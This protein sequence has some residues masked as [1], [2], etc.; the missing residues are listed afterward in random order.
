MSFERIQAEE[1]KLQIFQKSSG[2]SYDLSFGSIQS[3]IILAVVSSSTEK[4][5]IEI[6]SNVSSFIPLEM[7]HQFHLKI[8]DKK[9]YISDAFINSP[10]LGN[11]VYRLDDE[12]LQGYDGVQMA[13]F[14][15]FKPNGKI[16]KIGNA[17]VSTDL[18]TF[19]TSQYQIN[20]NSQT[21][22]F[23]I[24]EEI[25]PF[26]IAAIRSSGRKKDHNYMLSYKEPIK[27]YRSKLDIR[28]A[29]KMDDKIKAILP[30][31]SKSKHF[32]LP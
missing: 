2:N 32:L 17:K 14:L 6:H 12:Y 24:T 4:L 11:K 19:N 30:K 5:V 23:W 18:K 15:D 28:K 22:D 21:I 1:A 16:K 8:K 10:V 27:Y 9:I 13:S 20:E 26:A 3:K 31:P 29:Q 7:T 25:K